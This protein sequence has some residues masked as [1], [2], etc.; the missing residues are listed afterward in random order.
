M[1]WS[2]Y[3][4]QVNIYLIVFFCFY[5]LLLDKETYFILNRIYLIA[6]GVLS[7]AIPFLRFE[8]LATQPV[9]Q[10][11]YIGVDQLNGFV[12]Q[13]V[14]N[15]NAEKF[16]WGNLIVAIYVSGIL[17]FICRFIYQLITVRK[18]FYNVGNGTAFSFLNKKA[19]SQDVPELETIDLHE[20]IHIKQKH[21]IDVLFFEFLA[22][23][24]WFNPI[25]YAYKCTVK[26]I[27]E[28]LADEAAANFQGDKELYSLLLLSQ[29]FGT[30]PSDL[31]NGF[32]TK[33]LIKKRIFMLHK[34]RSKKTAIL[35]YGLFVPLFALTLI[36]SSAT[37]R[38]NNDL[39]AVADQIPLNNIKTVVSETIEAP[40]RIVNVEIASKN[41]RK[42]QA[43]L[44]TAIIKKSDKD[45]QRFYNFL[46][47]NIKYPKEALD[48][49]IQ[50]DV[51]INFNVKAGKIHNIDVTGN[52][53]YNI[54]QEVKQSI[55]AFNKELPAE[56]GNYS[57]V[58][59]F[60]LN[61]LTGKEEAGV[62][63]APVGYNQLSKITILGYAL[64]EQKEDNTIYDH[65]SLDNPPTYP[66]GIGNFYQWVGRT[67]RYP[68][69]ASENNVQGTLYLSFN[70]EKDGTLSDIKTNGRQLGYGLEEEA[71][72][73]L[74]LSKRWNPGTQ[75]NKPIRVKYNIPL[76]FSMP[77]TA[78][79]KKPADQ[80]KSFQEVKTNLPTDV[81]IVIDGKKEDYLTFKN[82]KTESIESI[83]VLKDAA[84]IAIYGKMGEN[85][86]VL[87]ETKKETK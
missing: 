30:R 37:V 11:M 79:I 19:I 55:L 70:I 26:N 86:V 36:L 52:L 13:S 6:S 17:F 77:E 65:V 4:L 67:I 82:M 25:I 42:N 45:W 40:L 32:F 81:L 41:Y 69:T 33:S 85:G 53:G 56:D 84:A 73:V 10:R 29:A 75:N 14:T 23:F 49:L 68:K 1:S 21:T 54:E 63:K 71:I 58:T 60:Q 72:R 48:N 47:S 31:T 64:N 24:M 15:P 28:F 16:N 66:G 18:M 76:K 43:P 83:A 59:A 9:A 61:Q 2:H 38:K 20:E 87:I 35:K 22:I 80:V 78:G 12:I 74:K 7:L 5:K 46:A 39:L 3:L 62:N 34:Q 57:F 51:R 8:W 44:S 27:H 50:G